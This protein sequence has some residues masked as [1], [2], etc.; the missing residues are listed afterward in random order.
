L[1]VV[2]ALIRFTLVWGGFLYMWLCSNYIDLL[3]IFFNDVLGSNKQLLTLKSP[4]CFLMRWKTIIP[5]I[6]MIGLLTS[7][8]FWIHFFHVINHNF[9][10]HIFN[11]IVG[12]NQPMCSDVFLHPLCKWRV[13]VMVPFICIMLVIELDQHL[14]DSKLMNARGIMYP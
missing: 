1:E 14:L 10:V 5:Q 12:A 9:Q 6:P 7:T 2:N 4:R 13:S 3:N 8:I 11:T